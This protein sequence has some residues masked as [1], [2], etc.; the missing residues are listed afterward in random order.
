MKRPKVKIRLPQI[1]ALQALKS[2]ELM[3]QVKICRA[4]GFS[5][6][7]GTIRS[8]INGVPEGSS[9]GPARP[10]LVTLGLVDRVELDIE[11]VLE[12]VYRITDRG[13]ARLEQEDRQLPPLRDKDISTNRRYKE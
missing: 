5:E 10:G 12:V 4:C 7:S 6:K 3:T 9:S 1:R 13:L 8:I 11:G 2:G